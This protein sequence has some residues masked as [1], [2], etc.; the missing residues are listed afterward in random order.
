[1]PSSSRITRSPSRVQHDGDWLVTPINSGSRCTCGS[2]AQLEEERQRLATQC[3]GFQQRVDAVVAAEQELEL[4]A[5]DLNEDFDRLDLGGEELLWSKADAED[6]LAEADQQLRALA[7]SRIAIAATEEGLLKEA[8]ELQELEA[9]VLAEEAR[10]AEEESQLLEARN[11]AESELRRFRKAHEEVEE[12]ESSFHLEMEDC[13]R[14]LDETERQQWALNADR[15]LLA[16]IE[17]QVEPIRRRLM[18]RE[19]RL[20]VEEQ[21][22]S[23]READCD[24]R[25][26]SLSPEYQYHIQALVTAE[27]RHREL[28]SREQES[29]EQQRRLIQ[30]QRDLGCTE[31]RLSGQE[32]A[33]RQQSSGTLKSLS[34]ES[35]KEVRRKLLRL[36][37]SESDW[38]ERLRLQQLEVQKLEARLQHL[39]ASQSQSI[40]DQRGGRKYERL[41]SAKQAWDREA[42]ALQNQH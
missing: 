11:L 39:Q 14:Q 21:E 10:I 29:L 25:E 37:S 17:A 8:A 40:M 31:I 22:L 4:R 30:R 3:H 33:L 20:E 16:E 32:G 13:G 5:A 28:E 26:T 35:D 1:M 12:E 2:A 42:H 27:S 18:E 41:S 7:E 19:L 34:V 38:A 36:R 6:G 23:A 15:Q 9:E 24:E